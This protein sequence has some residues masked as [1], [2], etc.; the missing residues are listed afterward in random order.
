MS[1][2]NSRQRKQREDTEGRGGAL[3]AEDEEKEEEEKEGKEEEEEETSQTKKM[4][5]L[6]ENKSDARRSKTNTKRV[7][8]DACISPSSFFSPIYTHTHGLSED[9]YA[10][11]GWSCKGRQHHT[12]CWRHTG[13][14]SAN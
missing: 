5:D 10:N 7:D 13:L 9:G 6:R 8:S 4:T 3:T 14:L 12:P 2:A 1:E 11:T